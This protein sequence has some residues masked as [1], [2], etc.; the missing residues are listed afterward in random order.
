MFLRAIE[1]FLFA[2]RWLLL[3]F[4]VGLSLGLLELILR[5]GKEMLD[6]T[7][8]VFSGSDKEVLSGVLSLIELTL[9][10]AL[11]VIVILSSYE[12]FVSRVSPKNHP[13]WPHWMGRVDFSELK[14]GMIAVI[15]TIVSVQILKDIESINELTDR[16]LAWLIAI[17]IAIVVTAVLLALADR[18]S[19]NRDQGP[20]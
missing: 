4:L 9:T 6:M 18:L 20:D 8:I 2:S 19:P 17:Q 1:R 3:P 11:I 15:S 13:E 5:L 10:A 16:Y 12:N 14:R 7:Q